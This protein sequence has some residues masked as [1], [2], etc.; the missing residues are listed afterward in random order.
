MAGRG[1]IGRQMLA[2]LLVPAVAAGAQIARSSPSPPRPRRR[3]RRSAPRRDRRAW[4]PASRR[5]GR[6][7]LT[8]MIFSVVAFSLTVMPFFRVQLNAVND[9]ISIIRKSVANSIPGKY[10]RL[11]YECLLVRRGHKWQGV[12][13][14]E[15]VSLPLRYC[16]LRGGGGS[17]A[18][19]RLLINYFRVS[20]FAAHLSPCFPGITCDTDADQVQI[21]PEVEPHAES[22]TDKKEADRDDR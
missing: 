21:K 1:V 13:V 20:P 2:V 7:H 5:P 11:K 19:L 22:G 14:Q 18:Y 17:S 8:E 16:G 4:C 12:M 10:R 3:P 9:S 6:C 15:M